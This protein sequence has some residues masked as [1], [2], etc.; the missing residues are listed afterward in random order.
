MS[1]IYSIDVDIVENEHKKIEINLSSY[2]REMFIRN[3]Q[4]VDEQSKQEEFKTI[5]NT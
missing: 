4:D 1:R 2:S 3:K 5:S